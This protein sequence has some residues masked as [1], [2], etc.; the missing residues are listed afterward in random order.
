MIQKCLTLMIKQNIK[1]HNLNCP[2]FPD[3]PCRILKIGGSG[4]R[5]PNL[6]FNLISHLLN[7][8]K[9]YLY[10][11]YSFEA[12]Y[13]LLI[14]KRESTGLKHFSDSKAVIEY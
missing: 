13:Q 7:I 10:P 8:D 1:E 2:Q 9:I 5:R 14:N 12:K 4:S 11:K 3:N 6:L